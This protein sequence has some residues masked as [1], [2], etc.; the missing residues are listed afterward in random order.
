M[1]SILLKIREVRELVRKEKYF[2]A[3]KLVY[4]IIGELGGFTGRAAEG[5]P[6]DL[7]T[8]VPECEALV[9]DCD[10]R[11]AGGVIFLALLQILGPV[12]LEIIKKRIENRTA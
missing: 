7:Q 2:E 6:E 5:T 3:A 8:C 11:A 4:E 12:L 9:N 1:F 10:G